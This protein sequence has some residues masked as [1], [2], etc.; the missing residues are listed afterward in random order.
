MSI[1]DEIGKLD[2]FVQF[3]IFLTFIIIVIGV[4]L[5]SYYIIRRKQLKKV[6]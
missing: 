4:I 6:L 1:F 5:Q 2:G 3:L